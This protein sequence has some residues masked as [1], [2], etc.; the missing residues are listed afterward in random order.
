MF[1]TPTLTPLP[2]ITWGKSGHSRS[3]V[4]LQSYKELDISCS[5]NN[6]CSQKI[7]NPIFNYILLCSIYKYWIAGHLDWFHPN[8]SDKSLICMLINLTKTFKSAVK[9]WASTEKL[10]WSNWAQS[11]KTLNIFAQIGS[12]S[13]SRGTCFRK[14]IFWFTVARRSTLKFYAN[15]QVV[16]YITMHHPSHKHMCV[17]IY[18]YNLHADQHELRQQHQTQY[19]EWW[20]Q[21]WW[22]HLHE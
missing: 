10:M 15:K 17:Y 11:S 13:L 5:N 12:F 20:R 9:H 2:S 1:I 3:P 19:A 16:S 6:K 22:S 14:T 8:L 21:S 18:I 7:N 4:F